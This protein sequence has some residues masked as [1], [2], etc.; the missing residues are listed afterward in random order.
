LFKSA[1]STCPATTSDYA[2][3]QAELKRLAR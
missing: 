2:S 3:A 1:V